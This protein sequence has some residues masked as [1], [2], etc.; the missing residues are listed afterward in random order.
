MN[1]MKQNAVES[2]LTA[3]THLILRTPARTVLLIP[4]MKKLK[5][6]DAREHT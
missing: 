2:I 5:H 6:R 4:Q 3:K 1:S